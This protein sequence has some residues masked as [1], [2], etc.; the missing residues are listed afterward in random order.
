MNTLRQQLLKDEGYK[1]F[2]YKCTAGK[3]TIGIGR[4][5]SDRGLTISEALFLL[6]NDIKVCIEDLN[7]RMKLSRLPNDIQDVLINMRFQ[8]GSSGFWKFKK[9]LTAFNKKDYEEAIVQMKDSKWYTQVPN[10]A[11]RLIKTVEQYIKE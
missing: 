7:A 11:K 2:P 6:D 4:N 9:M 8:L 3:L 1:Q 10:R 5:I